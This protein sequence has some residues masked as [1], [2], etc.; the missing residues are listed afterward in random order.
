MEAWDWEVR[1]EGGSEGSVERMWVEE[2]REFR[3]G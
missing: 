3:C 2:L 1:V